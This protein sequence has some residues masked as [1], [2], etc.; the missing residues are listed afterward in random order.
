[1]G[2][3]ESGGSIDLDL[4]VATQLATCVDRSPSPLMLDWRNGGSAGGLG[5]VCFSRPIISILKGIPSLWFV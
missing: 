4:L 2:H 3:G 5:L 1:M